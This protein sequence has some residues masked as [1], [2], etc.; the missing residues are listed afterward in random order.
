MTITLQIL[1]PGIAVGPAANSGAAGNAAPATDFSRFLA[2]AELSGQ[3]AAAAEPAA[4]DGKV[5]PSSPQA[6]PL[7]FTA[8]GAELTAEALPS[9]EA[10]ALS[11]A[12]AA[13]A[14]DTAD[15][16]MA[17]NPA[18]ASAAQRT[19]ENPVTERPV[20]GT[21]VAGIPV[22]GIPVAGIPLAASPDKLAAVR[23]RAEL[24]GMASGADLAAARLPP[25]LALTGE[26]L[27]LP[28]AGSGVRAP[29]AA[30]PEPL[31]GAR[32]PAAAADAAAADA[33]AL[34]LAARGDGSR[35][36]DAPA[37][38]LLPLAPATTAAGGSAEPPQLAASTSTPSVLLVESSAQ[39]P[40]RMAPLLTLSHAPQDAEFAGELATRLQVFARNGGHEATL[41]LHPAELGRL[42]VS[43]TTE[44][45]QARVLFVADSAAARE[46]I[47]QSMPR[48]RELLAQSG[49][50]LAH[51]DVSG[52]STAGGQRDSAAA[53]TPG[54][55]IGEAADSVEPGSGSAASQLPGSLHLVDYYI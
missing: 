7:R 25:P 5:L 35:G 51:T 34:L 2:D 46:A 9:A 23:A 10:L 13:G 28:V 39:A 17:E 33:A 8:A 20:A 27:P 44:G 16:S 48:L 42:Q 11:Q 26:D 55:A 45:D 24:G 43:I 3:G 29:A 6:L 30:A 53:A 14:P 21:P 4:A 40:S 54:A 49:L 1:S 19:T 18:A 47:E 36:G 50:Q 32:S 52:Q 31:A 12:P 37:S 41:Q 38:A 22:V 15:I